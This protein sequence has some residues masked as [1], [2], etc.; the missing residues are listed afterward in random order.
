MPTFTPI[1]TI[2]TPFSHTSEMPIQGYGISEAIGVI[3]LLPEFLPALKDLDGFSHIIVIYHFHLVR[4]CRLLVTPFLDSVERGIFATRAPNRPNPIGL[5]IY[6]L[7]SLSG[8]RLTVKGVDVVS[9][10]PLLDLKPYIEDF[11][12]IAGTRRGWFENRKAD[13]RQIASDDRFD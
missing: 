11:D 12:C 1:G 6:E 7:L 10:T 5:S 4:D 8:N 3:E 2:S 13:P 9:G